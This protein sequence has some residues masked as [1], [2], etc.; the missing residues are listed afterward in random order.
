MATGGGK[1][2][3]HRRAAKNAEETRTA[4]HLLLFFSA[5]SAALRSLCSCYEKSGGALPTVFSETETLVSVS[6]KGVSEAEKMVSTSEKA[7]CV[8]KI[9]VST[10]EINVSI[11]ETTVSV[12][13]KMVFGIEKNFSVTENMLSAFEKIF[14]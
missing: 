11:I 12:I 6:K 14:S 8:V 10:T 3:I 1:S 4:S 9:K 2:E 5:I 7:V 13:E